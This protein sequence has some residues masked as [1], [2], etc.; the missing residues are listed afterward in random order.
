MSSDTTSLLR[1]H[2]RAAKKAEAAASALGE[3]VAREAGQAIGGI[4][5]PGGA[6]GAWRDAVGAHLWISLDGDGVWRLGLGCLEW[7]T[8][9]GEGADPRAAAYSWLHANTRYRRR[10]VNAVRDWLRERGIHV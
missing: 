1:A 3:A 5:H 8:N 4:W 6:Y 2:R 10:E 7:S 9:H